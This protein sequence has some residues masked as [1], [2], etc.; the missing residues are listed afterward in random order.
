MCFLAT[1]LNQLVT[2]P[3][4]YSH[5][6]RF[7]FSCSEHPASS[8]ST[9]PVFVPETIL[10]LTALG[11]PAHRS[12]DPRPSSCGSGLCLALP[13]SGLAPGTGAQ[14]SAS[15]GTLSPL[16]LIFLVTSRL[17]P[18]ETFLDFKIKLYVF[19]LHFKVLDLE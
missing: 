7:L 16:P 13:L 9:L 18:W 14:L 10:P 1:I 17:L 3:G 12:P 2:L 19:L 15:R 6:G 4:L 11:C 8:F 5:P